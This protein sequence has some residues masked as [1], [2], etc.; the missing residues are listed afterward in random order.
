MR[1]LFFAMYAFQTN[2]TL[3]LSMILLIFFSIYIGYINPHKNKI[4]NNIQ[5]LLLLINLTI[6]YA[7][8]Y[9][10]SDRIFCIITNIMVTLVFIQLFTIMLYHLLTCTCHCDVVI[11]MH[12]LMGKLL[13]F[14]IK[15]YFKHNSLFDV[16]LF[17]IPE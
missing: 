7:V 9:Q 6:M 5:E 15:N 8:S 17:N 10:G 13:K 11:V 2:V 14:C 1:S 12:T 4:V 3:I 16:E